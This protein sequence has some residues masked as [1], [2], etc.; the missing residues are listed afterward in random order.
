MRRALAALA[1]AAL[2]AVALYW[3]LTRAT[4]LPAEA[5]AGLEPDLAQGERVFNAAG[6]ASCHVAPDAEDEEAPVLSGGQRFPS[7]FGT[8]IAPNISSDAVHGIGGWTT[9]ELVTALHRGVSP[10]GHHYFPAL[11]YTT[12][13][14]AALSD[15]VSLDAYLRTLPASDRPSQEHEVAFPFSIRRNLGLWKLLFMNDDWVLDVEPETEEE[16]GRYLVEALGHCA[17]CHT[18]RNFLGAKDRSR[19]MAGAPNPTGKGTIPNITPAKLDWSKADLVEFFTSGFTPEYDTAGGEMAKVVRNLA[20][21]PEE[22]RQAIAAYVK[23]LPP[24]E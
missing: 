11:P 22:D 5:T 14:H 21:L 2:V 13:T 15:L 10:A 9:A 6:C 20:K 16:R 17:E 3:G 19:W 1:I 18:P 12:Y 4:A 8:F 23:A 7:P 24:A